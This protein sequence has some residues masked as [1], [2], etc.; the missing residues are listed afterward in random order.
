MRSGHAHAS[1]RACRVGSESAE[2]I[3]EGVK[4]V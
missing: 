1:E 2:R 4:S 3:R